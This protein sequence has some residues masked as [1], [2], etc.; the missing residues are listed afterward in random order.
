[1]KLYCVIALLLV[2]PASGAEWWASAVG[3]STNG[4][5]E[6][7]W[8]VEMATGITTNHLLSAG[9]T[10]RF[11]PGTYIC[12]GTN[13]THA[14]GRVLEFKKSGSGTNVITYISET[15]WAFSFD[16]GLLFT[17][18]VSNLAIR[19][20]RIFC[21]GATNRNLTN[22]MALPPG[23]TQ[24]AQNVSLLHNLIENTGHPGI[25]SWKTTRGKHIA[26]N[27]IRFVGFNDWTSGYNGADRGSG[28][29]LQNQDNSAPARI[30]GNISFHNYTTGM[31][32]Y[33]N[34]DV[35]GFEFDGNTMIDNT[36]AG[37]FYHLDSYGSS[38]VSIRS[39]TIWGIGLGVR[40]GYQLGNGG[41]SNLVVTGNYVVQN[42]NA[43]LSQ[44]D[45]WT[46]SVWRNNTAVRLDQRYPW[47]MEYP[48]ET[49]GDIT[50][51][52]IDANHYFV[53]NTASFGPNPMQIKSSSYSF[54]DWKLQVK[55]DS[56]SVFNFSLPT[57]NVVSVVQASS[58]RS[59]LHAS[60]MNWENKAFEVVDVGNWF[61]NGT[62]VRLFDVQSL[63]QPC[64]DVTVVNGQISVLLSRTNTAPMLGVFANRS[65]WVGFDSRVRAFV[66]MSVKKPMLSVGNVTAN[67]IVV[68]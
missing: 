46:G 17:E 58:D 29:Y 53:T 45:G 63:P 7:P 52:D 41:H 51:H 3:V 61:T 68:R 22:G 4:T 9:D 36:E 64:G 28:M 35:W 32:A 25:A 15:P 57:G 8:S 24:F 19:N 20:F 21:S 59:F 55:G 66:L 6:N 60:I 48:G 40:I 13:A 50:S 16:G 67:R 23:I 42:G 39:N 30:V 44:I 27:I 5:R 31:K 14:L 54:D 38:G 37:V 10:V 33:G 34:T 12:T 49:S 43:P 11:L 1:M 26:G 56:N 65:P 18:S 47:I 62:R 2:L